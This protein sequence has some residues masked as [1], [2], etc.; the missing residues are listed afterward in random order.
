MNSWA[1][2]RNW[3]RTWAEFYFS[4]RVFTL[5]S[6]SFVRKHLLTTYGVL[7]PGLGTVDTQVLIVTVPS[8]SPSGGTGSRVRGREQGH[9]H[10]HGRHTHRFCT[11]LDA[12]VREPRQTH[13][14]LTGVVF[15]S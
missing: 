15:M 8:S 5:E 9:F 7:D 3:V 6:H 2:L 10:P 11:G 14:V 13:E 12:G 4:V 1:P